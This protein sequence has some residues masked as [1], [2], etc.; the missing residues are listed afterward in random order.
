M[1]GVSCPFH[2][3]MWFDP[4]RSMDREEM[5]AGQPRSNLEKTTWV[6]GRFGFDRSGKLLI[7]VI[8]RTRCT[9][10]SVGDARIRGR[11]DTRWLDLSG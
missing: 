7:A 3:A 4:K 6:Q 2:L 1:T 8:T 9:L 11:G 10:I 5:S